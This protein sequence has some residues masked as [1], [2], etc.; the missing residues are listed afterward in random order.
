MGSEALSLQ[1]SL[2]VFAVASANGE[3]SPKALQ[4]ALYNRALAALDKAKMQGN[5]IEILSET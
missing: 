1:V 5:H 4:D 2:G 3:A